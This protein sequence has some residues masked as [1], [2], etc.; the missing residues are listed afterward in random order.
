M[1]K[2]LFIMQQLKQRHLKN[3][4]TDTSLVRGDC[5]LPL[6]REETLSVANPKT[7]SNNPKVNPL[8][9]TVGLKAVVYVLSI[10]G[11]C[12]MPC[13]LS[14]GRK[15]VKKKRA[16]IVTLYP[17]TV[18]L[19]FECENKVQEISLGVDAGYENIGLSCMTGKKELF[20]ATVILDNKT[21]GRLT[22]RRM[23]RRGRRNKLWYR[24]PRF[25]NRKRKEGWLPPSVQRRYDAHLRIINF[26][27]S[28]MPITK[29]TVEIAK[30]DIQKIENSEINE[31]GYQEGDMYGYQNVKSYL[32]SR[33]K[34]VCQ[35]CKT[36][37]KKGDKL[38]VHHCK[39]RK[40][41]G[42]N[43]P[44]NLAILHKKCHEKLHKKNLKLSAPKA[45]KAPT[46][47]SIINKRFREDIPNVN[48]T[49]GNITFVDRNNLKLEKTHYNDAFVIAGGTTQERCKTITIEQKRRNNRAI[50]LNRNGYK[51]SIRKQR[52]KIQPKDFIWIEG[53]RYR[54]IGIHNNGTRVM[55][56][57]C[58]KKKSYSIKKVQKI[59]N[60]G[61][62][63]YN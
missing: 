26:L 42:S 60:F 30:F 34:G 61:G 19:N 28:I 4:P 41:E 40:E 33:E 52:Y 20:S 11:N 25:L 43:R 63:A 46:F 23:Y 16:K 18:Q 58:P 39:Q 1:Y 5:D 15:L 6:N 22:E 27:K 8:Q 62:F 38:N 7:C 12:L 21:S 36:E 24:K 53:K 35:L 32:L 37:F 14:K 29:T 48:I 47:M 50:Q 49:Y 57:G 31:K 59:Y 56:E 3:T 55:V 54:A 17:F 13:N 2:K 44:K 10:D 51:P 9:H 45:Y